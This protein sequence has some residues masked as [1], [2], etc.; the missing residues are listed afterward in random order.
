MLDVFNKVVYSL[1]LK[2]GLGPVPVL[3]GACVILGRLF[4][5][6]GPPFLIREMEKTVIL[7][8]ER[9]GLNER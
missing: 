4:N 1:T 7:L 9:A 6:S 8:Q 5:P 3:L 2:S